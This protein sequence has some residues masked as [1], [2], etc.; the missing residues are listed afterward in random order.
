MLIETGEV[1]EARDIIRS[2]FAEFLAHGGDDTLQTAS[3]IA[4]T[5]IWAAAHGLPDVVDDIP[6]AGHDEVRTHFI[7]KFAQA[8]CE[9]TR[10]ND[11]VA[12]QLAR[13]T[14]EQH[15]LSFV[16]RLRAGILLQ[17][18]G[19]GDW[20][21]REY[22]AV[23]DD[24]EAPAQQQVLASVMYAEFLHDRG[25]DGEAAGVL[26]RLVGADAC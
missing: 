11:T 18:W 13:T 3:N 24:N 17:K 7:L 25:R 19:A 6:I 9:R 21:S 4:D 14:F 22:T 10:G 5:L 23:V 2:V 1:E 8:L 26:D 12:E 16:D 15:G 20:A